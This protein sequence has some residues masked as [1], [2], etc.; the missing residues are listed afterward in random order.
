M[1]ALENIFYCI[2]YAKSVAAVMGI[3]HILDVSNKKPDKD[4]P[5]DKRP[6]YIDIMSRSHL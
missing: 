4:S 3:G 1:W 5:I 2:N 6:Y